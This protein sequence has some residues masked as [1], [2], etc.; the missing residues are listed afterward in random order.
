[1]P[2]FPHLS[3]SLAGEITPSLGG[4]SIRGTTERGPALREQPNLVSSPC[5]SIWPWSPARTAF[6][7]FPPAAPASSM[8]ILSSESLLGLAPRTTQACA[9]LRPS[10]CLCVLYSLSQVSPSLGKLVGPSTPLQAVRGVSG[11]G[12]PPGFSACPQGAHNLRGVSKEGKKKHEA[13]IRALSPLLE[14]DTGT[15]A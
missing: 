4:M 1:M 11:Q 2:Q 5:V 15:C 12:Q 9:L 7:G 10:P 8:W 14:G 6:G 3:I 13:G